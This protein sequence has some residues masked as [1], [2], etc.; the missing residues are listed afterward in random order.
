TANTSAASD[1]D[2]A[3]MYESTLE[4]YQQAVKDDPSNYT[5][6]ERLGNVAFDWATS[7][8]TGEMAP[9]THAAAEL[10]TIA[11][12]AYSKRLK[13]QAS[14]DVSVDR[15]IA[16]F[17]N[18]DEAGAIALME[19]YTKDDPYFAPAW[20]N[21]GKFYESEEDYS[22]ARECYEKALAANPDASMQEFAQEGLDNLPK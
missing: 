21:L 13:L 1:L 11:I 3:G 19:D 9:S 14:P 15:A 8:S 2:L 12:D 22:K 4:K 16:T 7:I 18:G 17:Y 5:N 20:A 6:F 10:Y